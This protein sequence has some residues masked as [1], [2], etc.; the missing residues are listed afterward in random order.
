MTVWTV[1]KLVE[2]LRNQWQ[3]S[4]QEVMAKHPKRSR[5]QSASAS[6][7]SSPAPVRLTVES[8]PSN[9]ENGPAGG[10][11]TAS[12]AG[13]ATLFLY[14][15]FVFD[16][17]WYR[18]FA[19]FFAN[20]LAIPAIAAAGLLGIAVDRFVRAEMTWLPRC[21]IDSWKFYLGEQALMSDHGNWSHGCVEDKGDYCL[22]HNNAEVI[23]P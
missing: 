4:I 20:E 9:P 23:S 21:C 3:S 22:V 19:L 7:S 8:V 17:A 5:A 16:A 11:I 14:F 6:R 10:W 13:A 18:A 12:I 1:L 15:Q 2:K